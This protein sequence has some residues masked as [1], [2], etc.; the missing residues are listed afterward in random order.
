[1]IELLTNILRP[2]KRECLIKKKKFILNES[3]LFSEGIV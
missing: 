2:E 1:M 3:L